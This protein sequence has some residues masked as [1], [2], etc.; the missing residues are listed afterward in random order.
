MNKREIK[1]KVG[2]LLLAG[3][4]KSEVFAQLSGQGMKDNDLAYCIASYVTPWLSEQYAGKVN[5]LI[6]LMFIQALLVF[7]IGYGIGAKIGPNA[8]W[9][10]AT[11]IASI[12]LMFAWGFYKNNVG[13]YNAY[14]LLSIVQ[15]PR[16]FSGFMESPIVSSI[17]LA[18]GLSLLAFVWYLHQKLFPDFVLT[19]VKKVKGEYVFS[20]HAR[21]RPHVIP[22]QQAR[23]LSPGVSDGDKTQRAVRVTQGGE[24]GVMRKVVFGLLAIAA[25]GGAV[26]LYIPANMQYTLQDAIKRPFTP[27]FDFPLNQMKAVKQDDWIAEYKRRGYDLRCYGNLR[28]EEQVSKDDDYNCWGIIKSAYDNIPAQMLVFWFHKGELQHF[29]IE[30]PESSFVPLQD[31]LGRHFEGVARLDQTSRA[32]IGKD[33]YGKSLMVWP[34]QYGIVVASKESTPGQSLTL[35]WTSREKVARDTMDELLTRV[36]DEANQLPVGS[37]APDDKKQNVAAATPVISASTVVELP[38]INKVPNVDRPSLHHTKLHKPS[39]LRH[40]LELSDNN[41]IAQCVSQSN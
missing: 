30:F 2:E 17:G 15:F 14:L 24:S 26:Y 40:C 18:I 6:T 5:I 28:P 10:I 33:V 4:A 12:P 1:N 23:V 22:T 35:L 13:A 21:A 25:L 8:Q 37:A 39:D 31:F 20:D 27:N 7:F 19:T 38:Q 34:T 11:L 32:P 29:K 41:A 9:I 36:T 3:V 16:Q